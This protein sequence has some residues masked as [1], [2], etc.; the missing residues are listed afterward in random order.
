MAINLKIALK[1]HGIPVLEQ[2]LKEAQES[3]EERYVTAQDVQTITSD[4]VHGNWMRR[5]NAGQLTGDWVVYAQHEGQNYYL[6]IA[7]HGDSDEHIREQIDVACTH[8]FPFLTD[9][10]T[11]IS[12]EGTEGRAEKEKAPKG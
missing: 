9:I 5:A 2:M 7:K 11:P 8:Q 12:L 6:C 3:G 1:A 10:L 4:A